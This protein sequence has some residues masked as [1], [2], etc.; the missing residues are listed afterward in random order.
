MNKINKTRNNWLI[1]KQIKTIQFKENM[2]LKNDL[3]N[4]E[5]VLVQTKV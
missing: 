2:I 5:P 1:Y 3:K 4:R